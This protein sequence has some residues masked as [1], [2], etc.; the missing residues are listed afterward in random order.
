MPW[1]LT[2]ERVVNG[3]GFPKRNFSVVLHA[4]LHSVQVPLKGR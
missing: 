1:M 4:H 3:L 2:V